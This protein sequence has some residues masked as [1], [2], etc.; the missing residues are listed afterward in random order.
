MEDMEYLADELKHRGV[1]KIAI[2]SMI[3]RIDLKDEI[4][5]LNESLKDLCKKKGYALINNSNISYKWHLAEDKVHLNYKGVK[6]LER[7]YIA[8][9]KNASV[10]NKE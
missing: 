2:S 1:Q 6:L 9:L 3:P 10:G 5:R 7:N 8:Y 4:P